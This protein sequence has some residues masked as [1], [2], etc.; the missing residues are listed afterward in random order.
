MKSSLIGKFFLNVM[1]G[2]WAYTFGEFHVVVG[3]ASSRLH[4]VFKKQWGVPW[5][6]ILWRKRVWLGYLFLWRILCVRWMC[7]WKQN[8][9]F[10]WILL[11][12]EY[13]VPSDENHPSCLAADIWTWQNHC[14]KSVRLKL[15]VWILQNGEVT[16]ASLFGY[17]GEDRRTQCSMF[18]PS[19]VVGDSWCFNIILLYTM[20][21]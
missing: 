6:K 2:T 18:V 5:C 1:E 15:F 16:W 12:F 13:E 10:L 14:V 21:W 7:L 20:A 9:K 3:D 8:G 17:F 11:S 4:H 19:Y